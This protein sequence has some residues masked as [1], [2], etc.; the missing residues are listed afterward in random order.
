MRKGRHKQGNALA[1][2][3]IS[4]PIALEADLVLSVWFVIDE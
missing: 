3:I 1:R 2:A 4:I